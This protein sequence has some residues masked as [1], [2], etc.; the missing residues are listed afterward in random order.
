MEL[1]LWFNHHERGWGMQIKQRVLIVDDEADIQDGVSRWLT[2]AG[3]ETLLASDGDKGIASA[4]QNKP[5]AIFLDMLMPGKNGIETLA[6]LR[7]CE[8]TS[9]IPVVMLSASLRDQQ[10]ALDAGAR[11][12]I[13]KPYDGKKLISTIRAAISEQVS[14]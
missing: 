14:D 7:A 4:S 3:Y 13:H 11:F 6:E 5:K 10:Q 8:D 2:A 9:D 12:F 1:R